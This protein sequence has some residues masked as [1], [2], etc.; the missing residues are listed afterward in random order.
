M[1]QPAR[2]RHGLGRL[3]AA[4]GEVDFAYLFGSLAGGLAYYDLEVAVLLRPDPAPL[5]VPDYEMN[6]ATELTQA[7]GVDVDVHVLNDT[8]PAFRVAVLQ[9]RPLLIRDEDRLIRF[10]AALRRETQEMGYMDDVAL[11]DAFR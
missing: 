1:P 3:L 4:H 9:G 5:A 8:P 2:L 7:L 10:I 11:R 6:L